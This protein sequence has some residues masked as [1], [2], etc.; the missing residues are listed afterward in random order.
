MKSRKHPDIAHIKF[1][2]EEIPHPDLIEVCND[3]LHHCLFLSWTGYEVLISENDKYK[4]IMQLR[5]S[6]DIKESKELQEEYF[7]L[8][9]ELSND[10]AS[11]LD[12]LDLLMNLDEK[13]FHSD[14]VIL[15]MHKK[16]KEFYLQWCDAF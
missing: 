3:M 10:I 5:E 7:I 13:I 8:E 15:N 11:L 4:R 9:D 1:N 14:P 12:E 2:L 16:L 6:Q